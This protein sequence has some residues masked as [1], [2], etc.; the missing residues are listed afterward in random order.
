[1]NDEAIVKFLKGS[2]FLHE[3]IPPRFNW[4]VLAT[5]ILLVFGIAILTTVGA[6]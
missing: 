1:M 3:D 4:W 5:G 6:A 2:N